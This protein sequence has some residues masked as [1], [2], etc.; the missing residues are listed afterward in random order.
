M[1]PSTP[2]LAQDLIRI[3][4]VITRAV[5]VGLSSA[6]QLQKSGYDS[7]QT[8]TGY[9]SY[10]HCLVTVLD[11]HH[12]SEDLIAFPAFRKVLPFAP[13]S[14]LTSDHQKIVGFLEKI[15]PALTN[16]T[17][18]YT[19][20]GL[21]EI[22]DLLQKTSQ[23]WFPHIQVEEV[24]FSSEAVNAVM[25]YEEQNRI[26]EAASKLSQE[27]SDPPYWVVPFVLFNL[28]IEDRAIMSAQL[29]PAIVNELVP[30]VWKDQWAPM[31]PYLLE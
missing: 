19:D 6:K 28:E 23:I 21:S 3:H 16:I 17:S 13:Y 26:S 1:A 5:N 27:H 24:N 10:I 7:P 8:L 15:Q 22:I 29:P 2:N 11:S 25:N 30:K 20:A 31:K 9:I 4:K 18:S 12:T 14:R